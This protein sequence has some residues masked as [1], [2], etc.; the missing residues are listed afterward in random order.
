MENCNSLESQYGD[1][2]PC[3]R[4][5]T[6]DFVASE[7]MESTFENNANP[8]SAEW[9]TGVK[10]CARYTGSGFSSDVPVVD[11]SIRTCGCT[12]G[13]G[14]VDE[15]ARKFL[16]AEWDAGD[17]EFMDIFLKYAPTSSFLSGM[18]YTGKQLSRNIFPP[19]A[20]RS[21]LSN[22]RSL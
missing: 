5:G 11:W 14:T 22:L 18:L 21:A 20:K 9:F 10:N 15:G 6:L 12:A 8:K 3:P 7:S 13:E 17:A 19:L 4:D 1:L 16:E 2:R